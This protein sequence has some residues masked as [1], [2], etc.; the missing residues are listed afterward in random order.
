MCITDR[1]Y[2]TSSR[3]ITFVSFKASHQPLLWMLM[4]V[5]LLIFPLFL[6]YNKDPFLHSGWGLWYLGLIKLSSQLHKRTTIMLST[7]SQ[8]LKNQNTSFIKVHDNSRGTSWA[9]NA[10]GPLIYI[11]III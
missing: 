2:S 8:T 11:L 3:R 10:L 1:N 7:N 4:V 5:R 6:L 9:G